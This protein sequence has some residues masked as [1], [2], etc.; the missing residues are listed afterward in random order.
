MSLCGNQCNTRSEIIEKNN[1]REE[2][3][4]SIGVFPFSNID[5]EM[6]FPFS[7]SIKDA[8]SNLY[9]MYLSSPPLAMS[10]PCSSPIS[11][12]PRFRRGKAPITSDFGDRSLKFLWRSAMR[13][14]QN[15]GKPLSL[16]S[17]FFQIDRQHDSDWQ[18][19]VSWQ[20]R[21]LFSFLASSATDDGV[22]SGGGL[23]IIE[24]H[25]R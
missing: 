16:F 4:L 1:K 3:R 5:E 23:A 25:Y 19:I 7:D 22:A 20:N 18:G 11:Y 2:G 9:K 6:E 21:A 15:Q 8:A 12:Y 10:K 24:S 13:S 17:A 14:R